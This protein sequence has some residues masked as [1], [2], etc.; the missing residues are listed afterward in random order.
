MCPFIGCTHCTFAM[1]QNCIFNS[2][3]SVMLKTFMESPLWL[4]DY[5]DYSHKVFISDISIYSLFWICLNIKYFNTFSFWICLYLEYSNISL[6]L[7]LSRIFEYFNTFPYSQFAFTS[8]IRIFQYILILNMQLHE[9]SFNLSI[10]ENS[11]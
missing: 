10:I 1:L 5:I 3:L 6:N 9:I 4:S 7:P 8:N 11:V 2:T